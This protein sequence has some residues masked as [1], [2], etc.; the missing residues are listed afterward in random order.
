VLKGRSFDEECRKHEGTMR[1]E[2]EEVR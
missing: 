1:E 2:D